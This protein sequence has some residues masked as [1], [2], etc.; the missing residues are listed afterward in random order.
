M[1]DL[2]ETKYWIV[3]A[4]RIQKT[5]NTCGTCLFPALQRHLWRSIAICGDPPRSAS[6]QLNKR[7]GLDED[8]YWEMDIKL[9]AVWASIYF[10]VSSTNADMLLLCILAIQVWRTRI[11]WQM[12]TLWTRNRYIPALPL[13]LPN[14]VMASATKRHSPVNEPPNGYFESWKS[15]YVCPAKN[16][17][18]EWTCK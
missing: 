13:T 10:A 2:M 16:F 18:Y 4:N 11:A 12:E 3:Y 1:V 14:R 17:K 7:W 6:S 9:L 15:S 8:Q 5:I